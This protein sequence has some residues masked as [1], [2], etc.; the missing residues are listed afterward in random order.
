MLKSNEKCVFMH[1]RTEL[2]LILIKNFIRLKFLPSH[3]VKLPIFFFFFKP[4]L[5]SLKHRFTHQWDVFYYLYVF[6]HCWQIA[7]WEGEGLNS[8]IARYN[9][10]SNCID[11]TFVVFCPLDYLWNRTSPGRLGKSLA[12]CVSNVFH[13]TPGR[14]GHWNL[15]NET[16]KPV[17]L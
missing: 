3:L 8:F 6:Q 15:E 10:S 16:V 5:F 2:F 13:Q 1:A 12:G 17:L 14:R 11:F 7:A 9:F 4:C